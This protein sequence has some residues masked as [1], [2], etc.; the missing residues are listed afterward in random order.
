[1]KIQYFL[2]IPKVHYH[3]FKSRLLVTI[4]SQRNSMHAI[5]PP[6]H[7]NSLRS[8]L[9]LSPINVCVVRAVSF[10]VFLTERLHL[11]LSCP[12]HYTWYTMILIIALVRK[13][14]Q[15]QYE[16]VEI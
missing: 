5:P 12:I 16:A 7:N 2:W 10:S 14:L 9:I 15:P 1:M 3:V 8:S 6:H 13:F 11:F 4:L